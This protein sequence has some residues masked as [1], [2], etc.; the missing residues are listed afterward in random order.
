M[1]IDGQ[2]EVARLCAEGMS[3]DGDPAAANALFMQ[4]WESRRDDYEASIAA[5][6]VARHQASPEDTV[7]W[8]QLAVDHAEAVHD[9]RALP[10]LASLYLN[11]GESLRVT[12][13]SSPALDAATRGLAALDHLPLDGY[14]NFVEVGLQRLKDRLHDSDSFSR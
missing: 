8:N 9:G 7:R 3:V 13:Q 10:L 4:A 14:R 6:F 2:S 12:G 11:L 1:R 5:H